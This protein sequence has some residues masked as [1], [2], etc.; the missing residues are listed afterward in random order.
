MEPTFQPKGWKP[1]IL[2]ESRKILHVVM[3]KAMLGMPPD[4]DVR[5]NRNARTYI[6]DDGT[7]L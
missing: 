4:A 5:T 1:H 7:H 2:T 6:D 3:M